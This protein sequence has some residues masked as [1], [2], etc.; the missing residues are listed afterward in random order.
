MSTNPNDKPWVTKELKCILNERKAALS[1]K[2]NLMKSVQT[3]LNVKIKHEKLMHKNKIEHFFRTNRSKDPWTGLK[4]LRCFR[5]KSSMLDP[6]NIDEYVN[7]LNRF[8]A[9][10]DDENFSSKCS[11]ILTITNRVNDPPIQI[12]QDLIITKKSENW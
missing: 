1:G 11:A 3:Q 2:N 7:E 6:G 5:T 10:S 8:Y 12:S 4:N 9:R